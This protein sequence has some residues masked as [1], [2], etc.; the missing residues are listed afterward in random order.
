M[1]ADATI[2][3]WSTAKGVVGYTNGEGCFSLQ[4]EPGKSLFVRN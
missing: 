1:Y 2:V 4:A 3:G